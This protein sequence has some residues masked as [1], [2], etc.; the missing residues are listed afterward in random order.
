MDLNPKLLMNPW[1]A[2]DWL[3]VTSVKIVVKCLNQSEEGNC[4]IFTYYNATQ[5]RKKQLS[6]LPLQYFLQACTNMA[7]YFQSVIVYIFESTQD[8]FV[9][10]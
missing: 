3:L 9:K 6:V 7:T 4:T 1:G 5:I 8:I 10:I 2:L